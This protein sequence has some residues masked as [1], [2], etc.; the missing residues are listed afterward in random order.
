MPITSL[1]SFQNADLTSTFVDVFKPKNLLLQELNFFSSVPSASRF[2]AVDYYV[3]ESSDV[4][5]QADNQRFGTDTNTVNLRKTSTVSLEV[6]FT[7]NTVTLGPKDWQDLREFGGVLEKSLEHVV[8]EALELQAEARDQWVE[9][10]LTQALVSATQTSEDTANPN[11]NYQTLFGSDYQVS[12]LDLAAATDVPL[13]I[14]K[15]Q[16]AVRR[17]ASGLPVDKIFVFCA[18][19][20]YYAVLSHQSIKDM[21]KYTVDPFNSNNFLTNFATYGGLDT[22]QAFTFNNMV[23]VLVEDR[24]YGM[25]GEDEMLIAPRFVDGPRNPLKKIYTRASRDGVIAQQGAQESYAYSYLT[26]RRHISLYTETS[27][28]AVNMLPSLYTKVTAT[29]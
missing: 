16:A 9:Y 5:L 23:F 18:P 28:L 3:D 21:M 22:V 27:A 12:A 8:A 11:I 15:T 20:A 4:L 2:A 10:K 6:P 26:E 1:D 25:L 29:V 14:T 24:F 19:E 7:E 17:K 13:W